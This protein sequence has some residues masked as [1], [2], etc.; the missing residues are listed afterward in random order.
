MNNLKIDNKLKS[1]INIFLKELQNKDSMIIDEINLFFVGY[2]KKEILEICNY[3][4]KIGRA[5]AGENDKT[6]RLEESGDI[7]GLIS[8]NLTYLGI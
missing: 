7:L 4:T 1:D 3:L 6:L 5:K 2:N 8:T